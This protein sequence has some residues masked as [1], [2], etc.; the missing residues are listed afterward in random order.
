VDPT[1]DIAVLLQHGY[2]YLAAA[3]IVFSRMIA[4]MLV[5]PVFTR[6]GATGVL[7]NGIALALT[8]PLVPATAAALGGEP[9]G[10]VKIAALLLKEFTVGIVLGFVLGVPLWAAEAA[11]DM[12]DLQRGASMATLIDPQGTEEASVTGTILALVMVALFFASGGF[13]ITVRMLYESYGIWPA[14]RFVPVLGAD[15]ATQLLGLLDDVFNLGLLLVV[16]IIVCLLL[17]DILLALVSRAA[18]TFNVFA[19]SLAV[20]SLLFAVL[21][22]LYSGFLASYMGRNLATLAGATDRLILISGRK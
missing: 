14:G 16:P 1:P 21:L 3:G 22:V 19:L 10:T 8:L 15:A 11:G 20:K 13:L 2:E 6:I 4:V 17:A 18:P 9:L 7:R 12:L 5:M